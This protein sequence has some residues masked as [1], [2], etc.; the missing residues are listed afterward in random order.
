VKN[1]VGEGEKIVSGEV[2]GEM[3]GSKGVREGDRVQGV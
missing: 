1:H 3:R 2:N